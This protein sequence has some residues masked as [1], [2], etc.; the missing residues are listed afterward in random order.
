MKHPFP[1]KEIAQQAG[2]SLATVDRALHGRAHVSA[3]TKAMIAAAIDELSGQERQLA[4]KGRRMFVDV[5]V[6]APGRFSREVRHGAEAALPTL[7]PFVIRP[8]FTFHE[9][10]RP[11][12]TVTVLNQIAKRGSHGVCLKA[13]DVPVVRDA[14]D[15]LIARG[16]PVVCLVTDLAQSH[17]I[18]YVGSDN[19]RAGRTAA[20][21]ISQTVRSGLIIATQSQDVFTGEDDRLCGFREG[22][23]KF[24]PNCDILLIKGGAGLNPQTG[25]AVTAAMHGQGPIA[26]VYS[27]GGANRAIAASLARLGQK[28][29]V[30][31]A[32]DLDSDN[33]T[34][35]ET[36]ALTYVLYHDLSRDMAQAFRHILGYHKLVRPSVGGQVP[37]QIIVAENLPDV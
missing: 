32:H 11:E 36:G 12:Q 25:Q 5:V 24:A 10:M 21:L 14:V 23:M 37:V 19:V 26:G 2:L 13:R 35:L 20:R 3:R 29:E 27:M 7:A 16:I 22:M 30:Y 15:G 1:L 28:P 8:R 4:A 9:V 6:E 34:L 33:R 18:A 31:V 17:R